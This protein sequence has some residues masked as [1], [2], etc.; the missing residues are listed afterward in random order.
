MIVLFT[1]TRDAGTCG[2]ELIDI[3]VASAGLKPSQIRTI[4]S[5][6][7]TGI[8]R[9]AEEYAM[10]HKIP[11]V[12]EPANWKLHG[13][14]AGAIRNAEMLHK[15]KCRANKWKMPL[16]CLAIP[17]PKSIGTW[18]MV[19]QVKQDPSIQLHIHELFELNKIIIKGEI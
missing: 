14:A 1:G 12:V 8:D 5:G 15:A 11:L 9:L 16:W 2:I 7:A 13:K 4:Y 17:G 10:L 18:D 6:G 19:T 3:I